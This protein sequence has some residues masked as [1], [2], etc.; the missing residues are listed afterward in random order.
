MAAQV[1][2]QSSRIPE[3]R[4]IE[5]LFKDFYL[6]IHERHTERER[7]RQRHRQR[8]KQALHEPDVGLHPRTPGHTLSQR[9]A[10]KY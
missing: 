5:Q 3:Y 9:Q 4:P 8:E 6:F 1:L 7:E 10:L 2:E